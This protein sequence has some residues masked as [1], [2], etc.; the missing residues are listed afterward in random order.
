MPE[1]TKKRQVL[2]ALKEWKTEIKASA[3]PHSA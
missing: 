2:Q 1:N 3:V